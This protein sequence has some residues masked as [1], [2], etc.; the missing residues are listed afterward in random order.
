MLSRAEAVARADR[1][2]LPGVGNAANA[3]DALRAGGIA[4][5]LCERVLE[6]GRPFLG[7][8]VGMQVLAGQCTESRPREGLGWYPGAV[9]HLA[10]IHAGALTV[11][12]VGFSDVAFT[13]AFPFAAAF[14][15]TPAMYFNH[16]YGVAADPE[17]AVLGGIVQHGASFGACYA[18]E[19]WAAVQF[20]PE[21]SQQDGARLIDAFLD[22][23][24]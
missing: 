10:E 13:P 14:R 12:H 19:T 17:L 9:R 24:P 8:C 18:G 15:R 5:A 3:L 4:E 22:W 6:A 23:A 1:L 2:V 11:P 20:H 7:I 16:M 21:K